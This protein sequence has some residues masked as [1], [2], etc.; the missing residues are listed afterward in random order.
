ME[1]TPSGIYAVA[2]LE[3]NRYCSISGEINYK[4]CSYSANILTF[5]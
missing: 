4:F 5:V 1:I 2:R 3:L